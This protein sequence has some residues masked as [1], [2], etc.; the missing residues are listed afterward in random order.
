MHDPNTSYIILLSLDS[1]LPTMISM[2]ADA[3]I[4]AESAVK[5]RELEDAAGTWEGRH[6]SWE[7]QAFG[8]LFPMLKTDKTHTTASNA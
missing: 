3:I 4:K 1:S 6:I 2:C 7:I 8:N 5:K